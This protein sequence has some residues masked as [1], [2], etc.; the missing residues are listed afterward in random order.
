MPKNLVIVESPAK[1]KTIEKFLGNDFKVVSSN[2]HIADLPSKELGINV[3]NNYEPKYI[4]NSDKKDIV[5]KLK[6]ESKT[7]EMVWLASD[8]DREGEAIAWHLYELLGLNK[9]NTK[10]IVFREITKNAVLK[11]IENPREINESLV[12]AQQARRVLDRLV[13]YKISPVLW[14]KV[15]GG[16]SAG[17]V[18]SVALR[19]IAD[20]EKEIERF[21]PVKSF[22]VSAEFLTVNGEVF[23]ARHKSK[24]DENIDLERLIDSLK[25]SKFNVSDI[26]KTPLSRKPLPPFTTSTLQQE[27]S[28]RLGFPVSKTMRT[29][30]RLY[31]QG[32]ITYMRTDSVTL[33]DVAKNAVKSKILNDFG[34][35]YFTERSYTN[36]SKNAQQAHEA[37]RP[38]DFENKNVSRII[39]IGGH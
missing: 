7:A 38:T 25:N 5:K 24:I 32:H 35:K 12:N 1:A 31:E 33:S 4:V 34:E 2:G 28:R 39:L 10:R 20:K 22:K 11:S 19:L 13:G 8:E 37:V 6:K 17:R 27:A 21:Q 16:L 9:D 30:Q 36:K 15:K 26:K 18:Q 14:R 23:K 29:A 3:D